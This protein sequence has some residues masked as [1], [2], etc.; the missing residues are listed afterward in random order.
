MRCPIPIHDS[1]NMGVSVGMGTAKGVPQSDYP[2]VQTQVVNHAGQVPTS[3]ATFNN[4][5]AAALNTY[6]KVG[7]PTRPWIPGVN[8]CNTWAHQAIYN[9]TPHNLTYSIYEVPITYATGVVVYADGSIH[10]PGG[11]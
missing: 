5:D 7:T 9:S 3:A 10:Q 8:D 2:G 1:T 11:N 4:V 6:I